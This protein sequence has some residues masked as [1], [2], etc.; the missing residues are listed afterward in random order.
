MDETLRWIGYLRTAYLPTM[1]SSQWDVP[2]AVILDC[3]DT[4][5]R[6]DLRFRIL[7]EVPLQYLDRNLAFEVVALANSSSHYVDFVAWSSGADLPRSLA[8]DTWS[9]ITHDRLFERGHRE[10][11]LHDLWDVGLVAAAGHTPDAVQATGFGSVAIFSGSEAENGEPST[12]GWAPHAVFGR[13]IDPSDRVLIER[14]SIV[15]RS[16]HLENEEPIAPWG[17]VV[18]AGLF[19]RNRLISDQIVRRA[20]QVA[21]EI[22]QRP[23]GKTTETILSQ[24]ADVQ[25]MGIESRRWTQGASYLGHPELVHL[26]NTASHLAGLGELERENQLTALEGLDRFATSL[27]AAITARSQRRLNSVGFVVANLSLMLSGVNMIFFAVNSGSPRQWVFVTWLII[28]AVM[29]AAL[30]ATVWFAR[31]RHPA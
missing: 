21:S 1:D 25:R 6:S 17:Y 16:P 26:F 13:G 9:F 29:L 27:S 18:L 15:V 22:S 7:G 8:D 31:E 12:H 28:V 20:T 3:V 24:S 2:P 11:S 14:N 4:R 5:S 30:T 23:R 19:S 10:F